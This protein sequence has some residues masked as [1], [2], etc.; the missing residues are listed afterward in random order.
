MHP[1]SR[2]RREADNPNVYEPVRKDGSTDSAGGGWLDDGS[3]GRGD[4]LAIGDAVNFAIRSAGHVQ[5]DAELGQGGGGQHGDEAGE[6]LDQR[7]H[8][9]IPPVSQATPYHAPK[10]RLRQSVADSR[11]E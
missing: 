11:Y 2:G 8:P 7:L 9:S 10:G 4:W 1:A 3:L 5:I 6:Q